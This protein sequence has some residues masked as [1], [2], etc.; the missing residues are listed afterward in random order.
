[1]SQKRENVLIITYWSFNDALIQTYTLPYVRMISENIHPKGKIFLVTLEQK[2]QEMST[3]KKEVMKDSLLKDGIYWIPFSHSSFGLSALLKFLVII[4]RLWWRIGQE[5]INTIHTWCTPAGG[6]GYILSRLTGKELILDSYEPHAEAM[7]QANQ[8]DKD[9]LAFRVLWWLERKQ[10]KYATTAIACVDIMRDYSLAKYGA[11]FSKFYWKPAAVN[12]EL[13][14]PRKRKDQNLSKTYGLENKVV[15][16]YAGKFGGS[17]LTT[18]VFDLL[19][20][21]QDHYQ[22]K[23][24]V[25]LL[26]NQSKE[27]V[28]AWSSDSGLDR[29][30]II[31]IFVP[32]EQ[33]PKYMGLGDV[34]LVPVIPA[35][36]KRFC[37]PV[38]TSE[39]LS[40][41]IPVI[42]TKDISDDSGLIEKENIGYV[43]ERLDESEYKQALDKIDQLISAK[44]IKETTERCRSI[45]LK[46]K[47]FDQAKQIY[48][49]LYD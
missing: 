45:A 12:F 27:Q 8:W 22:D 29:K 37:S 11:T 3:H 46:E 42:I 9:S 24:A 2:H 39:Y 30:N 17:Y 47:N 5:D 6:I 43:L 31:Q 32:Y 38:K 4:P 35:P 15:F 18:E 16:I 21:A 28:K 26:N 36:S 34:G 20:I 1:M 33:V 7:V 19:K 49:E 48:K 23:F 14:H 41:G 13:F 10:S 25:I 44:S 40:M